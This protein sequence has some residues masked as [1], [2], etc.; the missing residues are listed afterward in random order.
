MVVMRV[1]VVVVGVMI[2][3]MVVATGFVVVMIGMHK[4]FFFM[5]IDVDKDKRR[6]AL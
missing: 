6:A 3:C 1:A 5:W 2:V 4:W